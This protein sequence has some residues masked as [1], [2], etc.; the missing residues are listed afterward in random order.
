MTAAPPRILAAASPG[1]V[2]VALVC[3]T[4]LTEFWVERPHAPDGV[5]D[6]HRARVLARTPAMAGAFLALG[7]GETGFLPDDQAPEAGGTPEGL[8]LPVRVFRAAQGGKGPRVT[9]RLTPRERALAA[10]APE[11]APRL[12]ARGPGPV[13]RLARA[14]ATAPVIVDHPALAATLRTALGRER[15]TLARDP[16]FDDALEAG[17]EALHGPEA[18][19]PGGQGGRVLVHATPALTAIDVDAAGAVAGRDPLAQERLNLVAMQEVARQIRLRNLAGPILID[20]AGLSLRRRAALAAPFEA[21]LAAD[22]LA[23]LKGIGP[24]GLFEVLR[25]RVHPPLHEVLGGR[26]AP[27]TAGLEALR[28][29]A[30]HAAARPGCAVALRAPPA[31][32]AALRDAPGV[33]E[34][35]AAETGRPLRLLPD[36][37]APPAGEIEEEPPARG[38]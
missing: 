27:L 5:G 14:W 3:G 17:I 4:T 20:L 7:G 32:A 13:L 29:A 15:V 26:M 34:A 10:A 12:L 33:L 23:R 21:V 35:Y 37:G 36:A 16:V 6:L 25:R 9:A 1:E 2:R 31:L 19:L 18:P 30:R 24:L 8:V 11:A 38:R 22:A 28:R